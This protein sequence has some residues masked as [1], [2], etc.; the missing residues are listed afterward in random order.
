MCSFVASGKILRDWVSKSSAF[1]T[2]SQMGIFTL[3]VGFFLWSGSPFS[4]LAN[5]RMGVQNISMWS[6]VMV[7]FPNH[8]FW[9]ARASVLIFCS[10]FSIFARNLEIAGVLY[11]SLGNCSDMLYDFSPVFLSSNAETPQVI[12]RGVDTYVA[13]LVMAL[14][15][16]TLLPPEALTLGLEYF[17]SLSTLKLSPVMISL[18]AEDFD[19]DLLACWADIVLIGLL[20]GF[21]AIHAI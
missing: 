20:I 5:L 14:R 17:I 10:N 9:F 1:Q 15:I 2:P 13:V 11:S 19:A 6:L 3:R 18:G 8:S 4:P 7:D 21:V 16:P 12:M